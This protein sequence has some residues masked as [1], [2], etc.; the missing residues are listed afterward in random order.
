MPSTPRPRHPLYPSVG[1]SVFLSPDCGAVIV[2]IAGGNN[3]TANTTTVLSSAELYH[4]GTGKW[5]NTGSM[6]VARVGHT[7][8]LLISG[9]VIATSGSDANNDLTSCETYTP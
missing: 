3:V 5:T 9:K 1:T 6:S 7:A 8:T 2:R 4:P